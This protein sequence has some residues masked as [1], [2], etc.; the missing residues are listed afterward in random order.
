MRAR[1]ARSR[2]LYNTVPGQS[3][4]T[5]HRTAQGNRSRAHRNSERGVARR[6]YLAGARPRQCRRLIPPRRTVAQIVSDVV[7]EVSDALDNPTNTQAGQPRKLPAAK[8]PFSRIGRE[9]LS[10]Y[11]PMQRRQA[12]IDLAHL[13][14]LG[15][16]FEPV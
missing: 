1:S 5:N 9:V 4:A 16:L 7:A 8:G 2:R 14:V 3:A 6:R 15:R 13:R 12:I 10:K 11:A